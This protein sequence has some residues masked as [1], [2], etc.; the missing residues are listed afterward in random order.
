MEQLLYEKSYNESKFAQ[1]MS[2]EEE[3]LAQF[4]KEKNYQMEMLQIKHEE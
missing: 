3:T 1:K 2:F 4:H